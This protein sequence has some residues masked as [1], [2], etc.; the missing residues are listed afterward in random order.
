MEAIKK[1]GRKV[2]KKHTKIYKCTIWLLIFSLYLSKLPLQGVDLCRIQCKLQKPQKQKWNIHIEIRKQLMYFGI[3]LKLLKQTLN[4]I[5]AYRENW[6]VLN[7]ILEY[8]MDCIEWMEFKLKVEQYWK[9][10]FS[11]I[12]YMNDDQVILVLV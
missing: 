3:S 7:T 9:R 1:S 4:N 2:E 10:M 5:N 11:W 6:K 12:C 8:E